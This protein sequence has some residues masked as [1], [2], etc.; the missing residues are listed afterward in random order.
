MK[1]V[2]LSGMPGF[3]YIR[4]V[5][6]EDL[7]M[8][9]IATP[10]A[11]PQTPSLPLMTAVEFAQ[12][13]AGDCVELVK[14]QVKELPMASPKHGKICVRTSRVM[15]EYAESNDAGHVMSNDSYVQT[16]SNP[17]T[18]RGADVSFYSYERLPKGK[19]PEGIL[20]VVPDVIVEVRS[21]SERW[22]VLFA[23]VVE[24]L[25]AGVRA[26]IVLDEP[27]GTASV[28][29]PDELQQI[30]HNGDSLAVPDV[31][32]GFSVPVKRLFE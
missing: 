11:F 7:N 18:T 31:L 26:V 5:F 30:F 24:Y 32:P 16:G 23:K 21:P 3:W 22:T 19:V 9:S 20:P 2:A 25:Q 6:K 27:T 13:H 12:K 14:G 10:I 4:P 8:P 15:D 28:Y 29:R 1:Q 17:D